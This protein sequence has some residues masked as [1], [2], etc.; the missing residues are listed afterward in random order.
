MFQLVGGALLA[1]ALVWFVVV[2]TR[3]LYRQIEQG[4]WRA[5]G[6]ALRYLLLALLLVALILLVVATG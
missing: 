5:F 6:L 1:V 4:W 2:Q 3:W